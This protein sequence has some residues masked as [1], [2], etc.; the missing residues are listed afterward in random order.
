MWIIACSTARRRVSVGSIGTM[1]IK[2]NAISMRVS[3]FGSS[4]PFL[5]LPTAQILDGEHRRVVVRTAEL[6][7]RAKVGML[8][9]HRVVAIAR[10]GFQIVHE[11]VPEFHPGQQQGAMRKGKASSSPAE[12][13]NGRSMMSVGGKTA[14]PAGLMFMR[15]SSVFMLIRQPAQVPWSA[16]YRRRSPAQR[17]TTAVKFSQRKTSWP[18]V[19]ASLGR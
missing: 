12:V 18:R 1:F 10:C 9:V 3:G 6:F 2:T 5:F 7:M 8:S 11:G 14:R 15:C 4:C 17:G 19:L 16:G 13:T